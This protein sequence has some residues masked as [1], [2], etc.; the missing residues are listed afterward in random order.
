VQTQINA[1]IQQDLLIEARL[2]AEKWMADAGT[3]T[4]LSLQ[5][6]GMT[7]IFCGDA[8]AAEQSFR[9]ALAIAPDLPRNI[10][11]LGMA[12]MTQGRYSEG[13][14]L[15]EA[16]YAQGIQAAD[17]VSFAGMDPHRQW[18]GETLVGKRVLLIGEQGYGDH[19]QFIRFAAE[20]R[21][22]G[23]CKIMAL[24]RPA[25][26]GALSTAL[27]VDYLYSEMPDPDEYDLWCPLLSSLLHLQISSARAPAH[28]PYLFALPHQTALWHERINTWGQHKPK[29][30][31]VWAG[32]TGNSVDSRRSLSTHQA[33]ELVVSC[34]KLAFF[35]LQ[36]GSAGMDA[37]DRQCASGI[38]PLLDLLTD[39]TETAAAI[40][41]LDLI[42]SV[43]TAVAHLAGAMGKPIWLLLPAG[44]D[45]RWGQQG[46]ATPW[47]PS[48]RIFRQKIA[49]DWRGVL[50]S[51]AKELQ[52]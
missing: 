29:V 51:V 24:V 18:Q 1:L 2:L 4:L 17:K 26:L 11:N 49:G 8:S 27:C 52:A 28:T 25:L 9:S 48:M 42:I 23:A 34:T 40:A 20:L 36:L 50:Q 37:L 6:A 47:Y 32:S 33:L 43:D 38:I 13:L 45:W 16:R 19:F 15:Y 3:D 21:A 7:Q 44:A 39:F 35:S 30:G 14:P 46:N 10:A 31:L 5:Y 22:S 41:N 12:L